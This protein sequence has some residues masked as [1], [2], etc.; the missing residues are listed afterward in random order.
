MSEQPVI[1][2]MM[3]SCDQALNSFPPNQS[4]LLQTKRLLQWVP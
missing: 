4:S 1:L 2:A 3:P